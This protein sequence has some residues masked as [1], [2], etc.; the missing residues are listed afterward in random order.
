L[1]SRAAHFENRRAGSDSRADRRIERWATTGLRSLVPQ[2]DYTSGVPNLAW[3]CA[4]RISRQFSKA[5]LPS[6]LGD[7]VG[8]N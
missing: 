7:G 6:A 1:A 5:L 4:N 3:V 8:H 2:I